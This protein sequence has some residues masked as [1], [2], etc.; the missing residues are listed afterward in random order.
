M[1]DF[2]AV[3]STIGNISAVSYGKSNETSPAVQP[4]A[5]APAQQA[6]TVDTPEVLP[7]FPGGELAMYKALMDE[8]KWPEAVKPKGDYDGLT[9]VGFTVMA[10]GT[11]TNV[12]RVKSCGYGDLDAEAMRAV[13]TA[14]S[15]KWEPGTVGG[16]PVNCTFAVPVRFATK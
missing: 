7:Q 5:Q 2:P 6:E 3:A 10:D 16:K 12:T 15:V 1:T 9:V 11:V 13:K 14:L 4:S 8:V